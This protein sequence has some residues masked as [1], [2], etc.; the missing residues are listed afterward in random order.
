MPSNQVTVSARVSKNLKE[1]L[2]RKGVKVSDAIRRGLERELKELRIKELE[3]SLKKI[4]FSKV[5]E[6][7]IIRDIRKMRE[8]R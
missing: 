8:E 5:S 4:D 6:G 3:S 7:Q 2:E 1:E